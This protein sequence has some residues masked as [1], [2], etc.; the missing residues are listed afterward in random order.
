MK[1]DEFSQKAANIIRKA[2]IDW[3]ISSTASAASHMPDMLESVVIDSK[4]V[5]RL[6]ENELQKRG[7][8]PLNA[9]LHIFGLKI[10]STKNTLKNLNEQM[11]V[12]PQM[13][14][15]AAE[16]DIKTPFILKID[17]EKLKSAA[18]KVVSE[19]AKSEAVQNDRYNAVSELNKN[20]QAENERL[21]ADLSQIVTDLVYQKK[22]V[23]ERAQYMFSICKDES[24]DILE[25]IGGLLD[26]LDMQA[27]WRFED[28]DIK[29]VSEQ[30]MFQIIKCTDSEKRLPRPCIVSGGEV[31]LKGIKF[32]AV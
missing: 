8:N 14:I 23:A 12:L 18:E 19:L 27:Y 22:A 9:F 17:E 15:E 24:K 30:A 4:Y 5:T 13:G 28:C 10:V 16:K 21:S 29:G 2:C 31:L 20:F 11:T 6:I 26:D 25:Q 1:R 7:S 3:K 32:T